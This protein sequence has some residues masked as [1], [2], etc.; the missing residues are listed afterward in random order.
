M[1][2]GSLFAGIGGF[3]LGFERA[4]MRC[5]WQVEIDAYR[6]EVLSK[7]WPD[8][9]KWDDVRTFTGEGFERPDVICGGF[10]CQDVSLA[11]KREGLAGERSGLWSQFAR[12][13]RLLRPR[14]V[15]VENVSGILS[16]VDDGISAAIGPVLGDLAACG[17]DAEWQSIPAS[18]F[19]STQERY[20]VFIIAYL[21]GERNGSRVLSTRPHWQ[22]D[23]DAQRRS[24]GK[25]GHANAS[26]IGCGSG[27]SGRTNPFREMREAAWQDGNADAE[28]V[29]RRQRSAKVCNQSGK[30]RS[31]SKPH[32]CD[33]PFIGKGWWSSE[34]PVVRMVYGVPRKMVRDSI[35]GLGDC[36]VP[37]VAEWIGRR[38]VDADRI[39]QGTD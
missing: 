28:Q 32:R 31:S 21:A 33:S 20:R 22:E 13:I 35:A 39:R 37:Q 9:P 3:D 29:E 1:T 38:I 10:P 8:V 4:G 30:R 25:Q 11:G 6:R 19:G 14:C 18:A 12:I 16:P 7:H 36:V 27:R 34:P 24:V 15:V 5:V 17:F 26:G 2:F 23:S